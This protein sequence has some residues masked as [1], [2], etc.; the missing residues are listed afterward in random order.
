MKKAILILCLLLTGL[1]FVG[2]DGI[3]TLTTLLTSNTTA[4]ETTTSTTGT[5]G[6]TSSTTTS[7][8]TVPTTTTSTTITLP[9]DESVILKGAK[10]Y[11]MADVDVPVD[12]SGYRYQGEFGEIPLDEGTFGD[13]PAGI[14]LSGAELT[15]TVKGMY[16]L[17]FTAGTTTVPVIVFAKLAEE[18]EYV[19]FE[20]S[21]SELPNGA[22]PEGY[23]ILTGTANINGGKLR[24]DGVATTPSRVLLPNYLNGFRNYVI[25]TDFTILQANEQTRWASVM[26]RYGTTGYFQM[27][28]RQNAV[29]ANG[30]EFAKWINNAWNVPKTASYTET[31]SAAKNY[32]LRI[33]LKDDLVKEYVDGA[34]MITYENA[35]EFTAGAIGFQASGA[36]AAYD[37]I[38]ITVPADYVDDN[39]YE[40]T[41]IPTLYEPATGIQL[42]PTVMTLA[43]SYADLQA[44]KNEEVRPQALVLTVDHTLNVVDPSGNP[45]ATIL[46]ALTTIDGRAIPAFRVHSAAVAEAVAVL[47]KR[48]GIRDVFL[49]SES[50]EAIAVARSTY[51]MLRGILE[52]PYDAGNPVLDDEDRLAIRDAVNVCGALGAMLPDEYARK[53]NVDYLQRR[54]VA[55]FADATGEDGAMYASV[56]A[57]VDGMIV[58]DLAETYSFYGQFPDNSLIRQPLVI[59]HRGMP[60]RAPENTVE[61]SLLA[62]QSGADV[63]ELDIYLTTDGRIVVMHDA[64][65]ARTTNGTL[66]V[67]EST[68]AQIKALTI[69]DSTGNYPGLKVPTLDEYFDAFEN[70]DVQIFIEIK[71]SKPEIVPVL[72]ELVESYGIGDQISIIAFTTAQIE[73]VR[74]EMPTISVGYLNTTLANTS[75]LTMSLLSAINTVVPIK[76]TFNPNFA[77]NTETFVR[78]LHYR[79]I[80]VYPWTIDNVAD[81]SEFY[82]MGVGGI[83][84]NY[85][86]RMGTDWIRFEMNATTFTVD[87]ASPPSS[88]SLRGVI[89]TKAGTNMPTIPQCVLLDDGGTGIA[90]AAN[91][92][93]TG[94]T[95]KGTA[96]ILVR[97]QTSLSDGTILRV[98][99]DLVRII[100]T[101]S[102]LDAP[103][104]VL[105]PLFLLAFVPLWNDT[106]QTDGRKRTHGLF[107]TRIHQ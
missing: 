40:F 96:F 61:G 62:Y 80:N 60:S 51:G 100:I 101:D 47:V 74:V 84:T 99:D 10:N 41:T 57:G 28:I 76:T 37:N 27:A 103:S 73:R 94:F 3:T 17:D 83:T 71:S 64:T 2:C 53:D 22:L 31:I 67:E 15:A 18:T 93:L 72:A 88:L 42:P 16:R 90:I 9:P 4:T 7:T 95:T 89:G 69:L 78:Q 33:D 44:I 35:S 75:N 23:Q 106:L 50:A 52:I 97:I 82:A 87:L 21:Y 63:I 107:S 43:S 68:L 86:W 46:E 91:S 59:G 79:G 24:V 32:R 92:T 29:A 48:Y 36:V 19:V 65:T 8:T 81:L 104:E 55:V 30:V 13:L 54:L 6:T 66:T 26:F 70:L 5:T 85:A 102:R 20:A 11:I 38:R 49:I 34:L 56:L 105:P 77:K 1:A 12:L 25:E 39:L 98:H 45:I 14:S 58:G